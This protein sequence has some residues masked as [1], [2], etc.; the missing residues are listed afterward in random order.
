MRIYLAYMF[1]K[2][3]N[4]L[5]SRKTTC[6]YKYIYNYIVRV[7]DC[8]YKIM[9][10]TEN[11]TVDKWMTLE[12]ITLI[13]FREF[14][15]LW[16]KIRIKYILYFNKWFIGSILNFPTPV[17]LEEALLWSLFRIGIFRIPEHWNIFVKVGVKLN[18]WMISIISFK[19]V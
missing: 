15:C 1:S 9:Y 5:F 4:I 2:I 14:N 13:L 10:A 12:G 6:I 8:V 18:Y 11:I 16:C 17:V 3:V 7:C 19:I